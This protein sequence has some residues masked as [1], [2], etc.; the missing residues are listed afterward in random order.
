[1]IFAPTR[2]LIVEMVEREEKPIN[3]LILPKK[4]EHHI[5]RVISVGGDCSS[6]LCPGAY[7]Y[8]RLHSGTRIK[9]RE[10]EFLSVPEGTV[11]AIVEDL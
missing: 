7:V 6:A 3:G 2:T 8:F 9:Y 4:E 11:F 5:G 1:M 10:R